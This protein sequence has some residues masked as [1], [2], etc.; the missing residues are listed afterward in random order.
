M[1]FWFG[2]K[3][4]SSSS[5]SLSLRFLG[6]LLKKTE[7]LGAPPVVAHSLSRPHAEFLECANGKSWVPFKYSLE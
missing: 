1:A 7:F 3:D 6:F 4:L 2:C 5:W